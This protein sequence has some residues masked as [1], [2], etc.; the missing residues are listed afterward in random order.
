MISAV[1]P[2]RLRRQHGNREL[3][4]NSSRLFENADIICQ[5]SSIS[6]PTTM[7]G[8]GMVEEIKFANGTLT[9]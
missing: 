9:L 2:L 6:N 8:A 4:P 1:T 3:E 5:H 7:D